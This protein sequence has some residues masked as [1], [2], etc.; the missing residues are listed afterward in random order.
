MNIQRAAAGAGAGGAALK[1][2]YANTLQLQPAA[3][4]TQP[5]SEGTLEIENS[6]P[7]VLPISWCLV[8]V[9]LSH[10]M[11]VHSIIIHKAAVA[12]SRLHGWYG[13]N[14]ENID[15]ALSGEVAL[16]ALSILLMDHGFDQQCLALSEHRG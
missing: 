9:I 11:F 5:P 15:I 13:V 14:Q 1:Y 12:V 3:C 2:K 7:F 8:A 4:C 16:V 10:L 6:L